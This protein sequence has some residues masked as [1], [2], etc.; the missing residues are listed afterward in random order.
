MSATATPVA[1][2]CKATRFPASEQELLAVEKRAEGG[3][4]Q[5]DIGVGE[6]NAGG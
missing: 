1:G 6:G 5:V 3:D 2:R 4:V